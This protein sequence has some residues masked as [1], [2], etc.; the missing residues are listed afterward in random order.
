MV[1]SGVAAIFGPSA[2]ETNEIVQSVSETLEIPQ[3]QHFWN[4]KL[5]SN[6][7]TTDRPIRSFNLYPGNVVQ[8]KPHPL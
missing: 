2:I 6:A 3:F 1:Q 7:V 4:P 8:N 5:G